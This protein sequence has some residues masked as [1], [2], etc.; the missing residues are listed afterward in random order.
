V[1]AHFREAVDLSRGMPAAPLDL[2]R[3]ALLG[4]TG[5]VRMALSAIDMALW[6][7]LARSLGGS[8]RPL[9]A[10][11]SRGLGLMTPTALADEAEKLLASDNHRTQPRRRANSRECAITPSTA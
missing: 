3:F 5:T 10:Y 9:P 2:R 1:L 6:D 11:D 8:L 7:A 4:V